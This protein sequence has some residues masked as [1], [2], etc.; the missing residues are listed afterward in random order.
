MSSIGRAR[1]VEN[2]RSC[3]NV[4]F[5]IVYAPTSRCV[6]AYATPILLGRPVASSRPMSSLDSK[7]VLMLVENNSFPQDLRV[8]KEAAALRRAGYQ[9]SAIAP[10]S[11]SQPWSERVD[12][13]QVYRYPAPRGGAGIAGYIWEYA[14]SM[15][16]SLALMCRV[17]VR[18]PFHAIHAANPP[19]VFVFLA[20]PFIV[21][22]V[23]FVFD[24]HDL[25]PEMFQA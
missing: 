14:Y 9:V 22:R 11:G 12:G 4:I 7:H 23:K 5:R 1:P 17:Y 24:H 10:R 2:G 13:V 20:L 8:R 15:A 21:A 6:V 18:S 3:V 19:D 16:A 25:I